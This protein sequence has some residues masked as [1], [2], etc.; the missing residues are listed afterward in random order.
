MIHKLRRLLA[1]RRVDRELTILRDAYD[2]II[3][4]L[5]TKPHTP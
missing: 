5:P 1:A 4:R 3:R 2:D